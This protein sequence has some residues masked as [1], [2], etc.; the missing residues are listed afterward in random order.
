VTARA[1]RTN[2]ALLK[3]LHKTEGIQAI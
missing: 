1:M 3:I 2:S